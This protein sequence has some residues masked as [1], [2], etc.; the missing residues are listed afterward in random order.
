MRSGQGSDVPFGTQTRCPGRS[1][2]GVAVIVK[3]HASRFRWLHPRK[4]IRPAGAATVETDPLPCKCSIIYLMYSDPKGQGD[5]AWNPRRAVRSRESERSRSGFLGGRRGADRSARGRSERR[6]RRCGRLELRLAMVARSVPVGRRT[7]SASR[8]RKRRAHALC[9][10][11]RHM[12]SGGFGR[13]DYAGCA[14]VP[15]RDITLCSRFSRLCE[16]AND[17]AQRPLRDSPT[18]RTALLGR[19]RGSRCAV[20]G[21][22]IA[23]APRP[24]RAVKQPSE[25]R[26]RE[27]DEDCGERA[28][29]AECRVVVIHGRKST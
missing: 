14:P 1:P 18:E 5:P 13:T 21:L 16:L 25:G 23:V 20:G 19:C 10:G 27:H 7:G 22:G 15:H 29:P 11:S 24:G 26:Q 6:G 28:E 9:S 12:P 3:Q 4:Q 17:P 2:K 8:L